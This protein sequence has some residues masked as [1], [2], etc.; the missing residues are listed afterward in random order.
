MHLC[1]IVLPVYWTVIIRP[2]CHNAL[3]NADLV[4]ALSGDRN[5]PTSRSKQIS[6]TSFQE[7]STALLRLSVSRN[8]WH[9]GR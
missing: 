2:S 5:K 6:I 8:Q 1:E 4:G 7:D 3:L 9:S